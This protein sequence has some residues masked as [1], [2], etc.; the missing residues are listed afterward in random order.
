MKGSNSTDDLKSI[1]CAGSQSDIYDTETQQIQEQ[2]PNYGDGTEMSG[3]ATLTQPTML[4]GLMLALGAGDEAKA[5]RQL[6]SD[7]LALQEEQ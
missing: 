5:Q 1:F 6:L 2:S 4:N 7:T 3:Y